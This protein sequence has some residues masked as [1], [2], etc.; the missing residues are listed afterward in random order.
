MRRREYTDGTIANH[1]WAI[2]AYT[3]FLTDEKKMHCPR[4]DYSI[5]H[6]APPDV[7]EYLDT[8]EL[9][10]LFSHLDLNDIRQL[11]LRTFIEVMI[12]TGMR[13]SECLARNRDDLFTSEIEI[14]GKGK[15]RRKVYINDR[16]RYWVT[17]YLTERNDSYDPLFVTRDR[18]T[19]LR[20]MEDA[21][22]DLTRRA[23]LGKR[24]VL[25][26]LRHTYGTTLL[27]N[28]CP[29]PYVSVLLGH[30]K[31]E[32]TLRHYLAIKQKHA[33]SAHFRY[34]TYEE[35]CVQPC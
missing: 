27:M 22:L 6:A 24:A 16:T 18:R 29:L 35:P 23:K 5:P 4:F 32:T 9:E 30:S 11:R 13:P 25:H 17:K 19:T 12:N 15:K 2:K 3:R 21:F 33:K 28:G 26:T 14:I 1:L 10:L 34:L 31:T 20:Y 8:D 7:V